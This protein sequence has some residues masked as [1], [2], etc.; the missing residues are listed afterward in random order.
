MWKLA[1]TLQRDLLPQHFGWKEKPTF[2][3]NIQWFYLHPEHVS[4]F[5]Q[6]YALKPDLLGEKN[7]KQ[8][9]KKG[10]KLPPVNKSAEAC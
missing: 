7:N 4:P 10:E 8:Q 6:K 1:D 3:Y 9:Q 5:H 2:I